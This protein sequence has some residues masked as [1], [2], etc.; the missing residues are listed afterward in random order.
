MAVLFA[1]VGCLLLVQGLAVFFLGVSGGGSVGVVEACL[2]LLPFYVTYLFGRAGIRVRRASRETPLT[3]AEATARR[4]NTLA[5]V[6]YTAANLSS[7][8]FLPLPGVV[9]VVMVTTNV[10][11]LPVRLAR[12]VEPTKRNY[13]R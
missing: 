10:L 1:A 7:A 6:G 13:L 11:V 3:P 4:K 12:D 8:V 5:V 2:S 9:K